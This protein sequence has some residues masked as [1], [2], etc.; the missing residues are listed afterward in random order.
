MKGKPLDWTTAGVTLAAALIT[1]AGRDLLGAIFNR[2]R[3]RADAAS[4]LTDTALRLNSPL[5]LEV[6]RLEER[7]H[8]L[9]IEVR[10]AEVNANRM[11]DESA[12]MA[13]QLRD[14]RTAI[15]A[16]DA[17]IDGLRSLVHNGRIRRGNGQ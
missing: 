4:V 15:L 16:P 5:R 2:R 6:D 8:Q 12:L 9:I 10:M 17:T 7:V 14:L 3:T 1:V 11:A 13:D